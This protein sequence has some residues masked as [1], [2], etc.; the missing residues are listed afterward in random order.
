MDIAGAFRQK[1]LNPVPIHPD[2]F[3]LC[4]VRELGKSGVIKPCAG[5]DIQ[6]PA[7]RGNGAGLVGLCFLRI[8]VG[9]LDAF[10]RSGDAHL[11]TEQGGKD[12][13]DFLIGQGGGIGVGLRPVCGVSGAGFLRLRLQAPGG[14]L[15]AIGKGGNRKGRNAEHHGH[16]SR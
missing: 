8:A 16:Q 5:A 7:A 15:T 10:V 4:P 11:G 3:H 6:P 14:F 2:H 1:N 13:R 9:D 12:F